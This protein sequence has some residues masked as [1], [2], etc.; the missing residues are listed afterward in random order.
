M[1]RVEY[2][3]DLTAPVHVEEVQCGSLQPRGLYADE[4]ICLLKRHGR[5]ITR[6]VASAA[7]RRKVIRRKGRLNITSRMIERADR[8]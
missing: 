8:R 4:R 6:F 7:Q 3:A 5:T 1:A 2:I